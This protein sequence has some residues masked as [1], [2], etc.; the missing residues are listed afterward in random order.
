MSDAQIAT[1]L[2]ASPF[3]ILSIVWLVGTTA[4]TF[5]GDE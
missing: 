4:I 1:A 3:L 2:F 5:W